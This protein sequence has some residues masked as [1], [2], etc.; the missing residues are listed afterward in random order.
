VAGEPVAFAF[1]LDVQAFAVGLLGCWRAGCHAVLPADARRELVGPLLGPDHGGP[2]LHDTGVGRGIDVPKLLAERAAA[3]VPGGPSGPQCE[4]PVEFALPAGPVLSAVGYLRLATAHGAA[5][6]QS[7]P[8][9]PPL[10]GLRP[11]WTQTWN[12]AELAAEVRHW[13]EF[14]TRAHP[15]AAGAAGGLAVASSLAPSSLPAAM[16]GLLAP[17]SLGRPVAAAPG[18]DTS[19]GAD[20][21]VLVSSPGHLR[22]M[23]REP[24]GWPRRG[25]HVVSAFQPVDES[26]RRHLE[27]RGVGVS[28]ALVATP[29]VGRAALAAAADWADLA[30][31]GDVAVVPAGEGTG[32]W[33]IVAEAPHLSADEL[34]VAAGPLAESAAELVTTD[35]LERD[36][37]GLLPDAVVQRWFGRDDDGVSLTRALAIRLATASATAP[38]FEVEV[39]DNSAWFDGH[40]PGYPVLAGAVQLQELIVPLVERALPGVE[41]H[42][43][44]GLKFQSRIVPGDRIEIT[45]AIDAD[46]GKVGFK[47]RRGDTMCTSGAVATRPAGA[48]R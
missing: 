19:G 44:T 1:G 34:R 38:V 37:N 43:W 40:F 47:I 21:G 42:E 3:S 5:S 39:P 27:R 15:A 35:R 10:R 46:R 25:Q 30:G 36:P 13:C 23:L 22:A 9:G 32:R 33:R 26:L 29:P 2:F 16:L 12:A 41:A 31:V 4:A 8:A 14:L 17:L 45:L 24:E 28:E 6:L 20:V 48:P 7:G 18:A 11:L